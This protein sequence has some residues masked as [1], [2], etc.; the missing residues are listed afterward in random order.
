MEASIGCINAL[1]VSEDGH[2]FVSGGEDRMVKVR[3]DNTFPSV[4][5]PLLQLCHWRWAWH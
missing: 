3:L 5:N 4:A 2:F 1:D